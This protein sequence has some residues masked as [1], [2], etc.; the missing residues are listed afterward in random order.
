M[1]GHG[2]G[3]GVPVQ[4]PPGQGSAE[5]VPVGGG[6]GGPEDAEG[7]ADLLLFGSGVED[8]DEGFAVSVSRL[9]FS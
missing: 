4:G 6:A 3:D 7:E 2:Q 1:G 5:D 9:P 8:E